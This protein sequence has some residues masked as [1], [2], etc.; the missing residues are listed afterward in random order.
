M[1]GFFDILKGAGKSVYDF[2]L[3]LFMFVFALAV[4]TV[5]APDPELHSIGFFLLGVTLFFTLL[6]NK[7]ISFFALLLFIGALTTNGYFH[8]L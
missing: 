7:P 5:T 3:F 8:N 2:I 1:Q 6:T 4:T